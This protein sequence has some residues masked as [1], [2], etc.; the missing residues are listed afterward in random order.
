MPCAVG[1]VPSGEPSGGAASVVTTVTPLGHCASTSRN[2]VWS[3]IPHLLSD[4]EYTI[5]AWNRLALFPVDVL[6]CGRRA[7]ALTGDTGA[8]RLEV[9]ALRPGKGQQHESG[10]AE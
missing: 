4:K 2:T 1:G 9:L 3:T 10:G 6:R 5:S 7:P 8:R